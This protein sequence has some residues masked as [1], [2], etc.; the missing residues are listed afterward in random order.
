MK[1]QQSRLLNTI[2]GRF[3]PDEEKPLP[4]SIFHNPM[5][6][7]TRSKEMVSKIL[8]STENIERSRHFG[9]TEN[10]PNVFASRSTERRH[11]PQRER[12]DECRAVTS[13][14]F[15]NRPYQR[16]VVV[17]KTV[18]QKHQGKKDDYNLSPLKNQL[19]AGHNM[20]LH[21]R[22]NPIKTQFQI[23]HTAFDMKRLLLEEK[24]K[25]VYKRK[26][27]EQFKKD[28]ET[29]NEDEYFLSKI[30]DV[31]EVL[32]RE[33][34]V[35]INDPSLIHTILKK[36]E[37]SPPSTGKEKRVVFKKAWPQSVRSYKGNPTADISVSVTDR[38]HVNISHAAVDLSPM[39]KTPIRRAATNAQT[40][41]IIGAEEGDTSPY[42]KTMFKYKNDIIGNKFL[43]DIINEQPLSGWN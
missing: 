22:E 28:Q 38:S 29:Q 19:I 41:E 21:S 24:K 27:L 2:M 18:D 40:G 36:N 3:F 1:D 23:T 12:S 25:S 11:T 31:D 43:H 34:K 8:L 17:V 26:V 16:Q 5:I 14:F 4:A 13:P 33:K 20:N 15:I 32:K 6:N 35:Q 30:Y 37:G 9:L 10:V 39:S 7:K 42:S